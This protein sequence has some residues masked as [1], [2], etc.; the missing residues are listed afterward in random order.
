MNVKLYEKH[1]ESKKEFDL[2]L[3]TDQIKEAVKESGI[4]NGLC[5]RTLKR[6]S[7]SCWKN[8]YPM[9]SP[10]STPACCPPMGPVP[11]TRRA[12]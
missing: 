1:I 8:W 2:I 6:I 5:F 10:M 7:R 3:I 9:R 12:I 4:Q 11:A